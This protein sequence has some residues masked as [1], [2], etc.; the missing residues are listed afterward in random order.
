MY[1]KC[2]LCENRSQLRD[3]NCSQLA[4][5]EQVLQNNV[6]IQI[7]NQMMCAFSISTQ[8]PSFLFDLCRYIYLND[9]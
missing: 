7:M 3:D 1:S 9:L 2:Y 4:E 8:T 5:D 6:M